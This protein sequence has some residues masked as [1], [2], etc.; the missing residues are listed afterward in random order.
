MTTDKAPPGKAPTG[1]PATG[2]LSRESGRAIFGVDAAGYHAGRI[3]YPADL[4]DDIY[5]MLPGDPRVLEIGAGTGLVTEELL[6]RRLASLVVVEPAEELVAFI[7]D[8]L[9]DDR[10]ALVTSGFVEAPLHGPFDLIVCAAAFHW[11]DPEAALARV[12]ALLRPGGIWAMWWNSYRNYG[13]GDPL[14]DAITPL[15][16]SIALPPSDSLTGHYS[17]NAELHTRTLSAAGFRNIRHQVFRRERVL[18]RAEVRSLFDSYSYVRLL[19]PAQREDLL[20]RIDAIVADQFGG[21]APNVVLTAYY[22]A[23]SA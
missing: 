14:A 16:E 17:L 3:G 22:S 7:R 19:P 6:S 5:A 18:N 4:Y 2:T 13:V 15:L 10:L 12:R 9:R 11:L 20:D 8:R 23:Q 1:K 21:Q